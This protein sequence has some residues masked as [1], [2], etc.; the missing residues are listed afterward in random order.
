MFWHTNCALKSNTDFAALHSECITLHCSA[1]SQSLPLHNL[2]TLCWSLSRSTE[3]LS[4]ADPLVLAI[5][6]IL[7]KSGKQVQTDID[8]SQ[9]PT[10]NFSL[11]P[12]S[13]ICSF[14]E[15]RKF[16]VKCSP[17]PPAHIS[18]P[19]L[20]FLCS[21]HL[22]SCTVVEVPLFLFN[23]RANLSIRM[24]SM[25]WN[26]GSLVNCKCGH[27]LEDANNQRGTFLLLHDVQNSF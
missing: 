3:G 4:S 11:L 7:K 6:K 24:I 22:F 19:C 9:N 20:L 12:F 26:D 25:H 5:C 8:T 15:S 17:L 14:P 10:W 1:S 23:G 18:L 16:Y 27:R 21:L 13:Q 2:T